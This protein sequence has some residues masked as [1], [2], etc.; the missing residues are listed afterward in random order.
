MIAAGRVFVIACLLGSLPTLVMGADLKVGYVDVVK[1][2][3]A[4]PQGDAALSKLEQEFG[5]RDKSLVATRDQIR[6]LE[7]ELGDNASPLTDEVR[8]RKEREV[9]SL[10][11]SLKRES[12]EFRED[13]NLRRNEELA[14]LQKIVHSAIIEIAK[15]EGYD[16]I[17]HQGAIYASD[18]IDITQK[19]LEK[20]KRK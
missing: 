18:A 15:D 17:L 9:V 4:A 5:P 20:L 12:Q 6:K 13:Y 1:I 19:V 16:L 3:D 10:K 8:T 11:R 2:I 7:E 14:G